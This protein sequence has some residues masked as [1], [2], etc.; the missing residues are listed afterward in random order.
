[1]QDSLVMN[2]RSRV[3][4]PVQVTTNASGGYM[5]PTAGASSIDIR[6]IATMGNAADLVFTLYT[7][8]DTSGTN[9]VVIAADVPIFVDGAA[10]TAAKANTIGAATGNFIVDFIIDPA[11]IPAGKTIGV[12]YG[13]SDASNIACALLVEDCPYKPTVA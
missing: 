7:A 11:L 6:C 4:M 13:N 5:A 9:P 8:D 10:V 2:Y 12:A 3:L 1:M